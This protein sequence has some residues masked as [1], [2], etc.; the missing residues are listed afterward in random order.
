MLSTPTYEYVFHRSQPL[1]INS[2]YPSISFVSLLLPPV[3]ALL[4]KLQAAQAAV[5]ASSLT[6]TVNDGV[7]YN[8]TYINPGTVN[9]PDLSCYYKDPGNKI[10]A[11]DYVTIS[12]IAHSFGEMILMF[13]GTA[14]SEVDDI[15]H[16]KTMPRYFHREIPDQQQVAYRFNE[17]NLNDT[18]KIYPRLTNRTIYAEAKNCIT[19]DII[20]ADGNDPQTLTYPDDT[21]ANATIMIPQDFLGREGTTYIYRGFHDPP[22]AELQSCGERC[23]SM[24]VYKNS[25]GFPK[26][27][28]EPTALYKCPVNISDVNN[29][30]R[31]EHHIPNQVVKMAVAAIALRGIYRGPPGNLSE[32]DYGSYQFY[33]SG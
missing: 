29:A 8:D 18:Q 7:N 1:N 26:S 20:S 4:N 30:S 11:E 24:W 27:S 12:T 16:D 31:P 33:P 17:Y 22:D 32:Q 19:Y 25:S 9:V 23:L 15:L 5:T 6:F 14:Y 3:R 13:T 2:S 10:C 28:P 21:G